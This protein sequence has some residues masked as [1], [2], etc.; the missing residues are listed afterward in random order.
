MKKIKRVK[1]FVNNNIKSR[2]VAKEITEILQKKKFEIVEDNFDI[3]IAVGGDGSFLRMI[4]NSNFN[5][6]AYYVGVNAGTLGFAQEVNMDEINK[7]VNDLVKGN[8]TYEEIGIQEIE[9]T[10]NESI[11]RFYSL[12][13]IVVRDEELNTAGLDIYIDGVLLEK[14]IGDGLL[15]ATSFGSTAYNLSFGG[16]IV[17]NTFHTLQITPIAPLN[18]KS[19]RNLIN[20]VIIPSSKVVKLVPSRN[21][22]NLVVTIDGDNN[23]FNNVLKIETFIDNKKIKIIRKQ[24]YNFI[25]KINDKFLK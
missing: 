2:K 17:Y 8:L 23:F 7:F 19:Y 24:N 10:T 14:Y 13:E 25:K 5:S 18:N 21:G 6:E 12:N 4:K 3:G 22:G 9:I 20:S 11:S 1:L 16:S 15:I